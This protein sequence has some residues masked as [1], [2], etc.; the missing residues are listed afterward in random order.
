VP[1]EFFWKYTDWLVRAAEYYGLDLVL[2]LDH[3]PEW[4]ISPDGVAVDAAAYAG[5]AGRMA[6][7]YQGRVTAHVV[8]NEPNLAAEWAGQPPIRPVTSNCCAPL[9]PPSGPPTRKPSWSVLAWHPPTTLVPLLWT[10]GSTC[11]RYRQPSS[12]PRPRP[13]C[14]DAQR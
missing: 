10:I 3:P 2:R 9:R 12:P 5:L 7:R 4:A 11:R 1:N 8:W 6:A 14:L 13:G